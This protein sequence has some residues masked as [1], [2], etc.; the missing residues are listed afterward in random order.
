[1]MGGMRQQGS[2]DHQGGQPVADRRKARLTRDELRA[3]VLQAG[4][5]ILETEGIEIGTDNLTFKR[6]FDHIEHHT[7]V[8][9][10]N[11]SVI[12]RVWEN[13][14]DFRADV[15]VAI[16][17]DHERHEVDETLDTVRAFLD[18]F[19]L[20]T[21]DLRRRAMSELCRVVGT[22]SS[23]ALQ[24]SSN[25]PLWISVVAMATSA[26]PSERRTRIQQALREGYAAITEFWEAN[27]ET[28]MAHLGLRFRPPWNLRQYTLTTTALSEGYA[29]RQHIEGGLEA[30]LRPTGPNGEPQEWTL[31][32]T[33]M[34]AL[35]IQAVE[36]DP[37]FTPPAPGGTGGE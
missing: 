35:V 36:L 9:L 16:A 15:L 1:M 21:P 26:W 22:S 14:A 18:T 37:D 31:F 7:G 29:M 20:S 13:Q 17:L 28:F 10:T 24:L 34:E 3:L 8:Q 33:A 2:G 23:E 25:W 27:T 19:D 11:A 12:R 4:R 32:G 5:E 30:F 6:V